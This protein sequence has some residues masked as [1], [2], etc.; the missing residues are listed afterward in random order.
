MA[1]QKKVVEKMSDELQVDGLDAAARGLFVE[2]AFTSAEIDAA[3]TKDAA[4]GDDG[5]LFLHPD[6]GQG[7]A[8]SVDGSVLS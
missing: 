6:S 7:R 8:A 3:L 2:T 5:C 4:S 1:E